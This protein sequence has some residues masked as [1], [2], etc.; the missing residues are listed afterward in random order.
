VAASLAAA[1]LACFLVRPSHANAQ[2]GA[3][4]LPPAAGAREKTHT[5]DAPPQDAVSDSEVEVVETNLTTVLLTATDRRG[6]LI[7]DLRQEDLRVSEDGVPQQITVFE[8]QTERPLTIALVFDVSGSQSRTLPDQKKAAALFLRSIFR[9][10]RDRAAVVTFAGGTNL[11]QPFTDNP[12]RLAAAVESV[13]LSPASSAGHGTV[14]Y[15]A[16][17]LTC[18]KVLRGAGAGTRRAIILLTDALD[19]GSRLRRRD[20]VNAAAY[21]DAV[22]YGIGVGSQWIDDEALRAVAEGAGGRAF[23]PGGGGKLREAFEQIE[24][25]LR[26]QYLIAYT[27]TSGAAGAARREVAVEIANPL[28]ARERLRLAY[29]GHYYF[30]KRAR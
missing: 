10:G 21:A 27:P 16:L 17:F 2:G 14:M 7:T 20:A 30:R 15:D 11:V 8:R 22:V 12:E 4:S 6:R 19:N 25:E 13:S 5:A 23:F 9:P 1:L 28:R 18:Y 24:R 29:R 26:S 3:P